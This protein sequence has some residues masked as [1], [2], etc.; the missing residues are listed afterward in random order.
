MLKQALLR[1]TGPVLLPAMLPDLFA[2]PVVPAA[3][4]PSVG[5]QGLEE[6]IRKRLAEGSDNLHDEVY[7]E[8]DR[9]LLPLVM[10]HTRGN[11]YQAAK[12]LGVARQTL[13]RRLRDLNI[14]PRFTDAAEDEVD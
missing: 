4:L 13:R 3:P 11:Q 8:L 10:E 6:F 7:R 1:A 9:F 5:R 14:T 2:G 12:L